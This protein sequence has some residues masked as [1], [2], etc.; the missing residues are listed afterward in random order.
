MPYPDFE[1]FVA[2][3]N[4][5]RVRYLIV[6]AY[7]VGFHVRPRATKNIDVLMDPTPL[8]ALKTLR[9]SSG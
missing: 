3:L 8:D 4:A 5:R 6:G 1:E 7:A 2:S 9:T